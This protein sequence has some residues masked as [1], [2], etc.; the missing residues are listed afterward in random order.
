MNVTS[1]LAPKES[2]QSLCQFCIGR[3][4]VDGGVRVREYKSKTKENTFHKSTRSTDV[5]HSQYRRQVGFGRTTVDS[6]VR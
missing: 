4:T 1:A 3:T 6:G 5:E 2:H